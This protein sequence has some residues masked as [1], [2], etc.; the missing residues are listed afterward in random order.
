MDI[1]PELAMDFEDSSSFQEGMISEMYQRPDMSYFPEPQELES[2]I[3][4]GR[5]IQKFLPKQ[6][7]IDKMLEIIQ[8]E[9]LK[10]MHLPMTVKEIQAGYLTSSYFK[11]LYLSLA[12]NKL[13]NTKTAIQKVETL[14]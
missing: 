12:Q 7:D 11:G 2:L 3:Y 10:G 8:R 14:H 9:V 13:P 1:D 6:A 5:I 4:T